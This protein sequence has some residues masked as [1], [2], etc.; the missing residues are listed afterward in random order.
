MSDVSI[1]TATV[2]DAAAL[3]AIYTPYVLKTA[4]SF[5]LEP[6]SV[7]EFRGRI[8]HSLAE[9][10]WLVAERDGRPVAYAHGTRHRPRAAYKW[11]VET[12][13]YVAEGNHRQ[14]LGRL[15]YS[16]LMPR[17]VELGYCNAYGGI[18]LPNDKSVALHK[19]LGFQPIGIFRS[20]GWKFGS[21]HDVSWWHLPLRSA[22]PE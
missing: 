11:S 12:S 19:S 14:G 16:A 13:V 1:R 5:E 21:W 10:T 18:T 17:L 22:P 6:P 2:D 9:W 4:I 15:V 8:E 7:E 20:V 3:L